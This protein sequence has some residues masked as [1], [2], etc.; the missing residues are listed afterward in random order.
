MSWSSSSPGKAHVD[1]SRVVDGRGER[2]TAWKNRV[3]VHPN[4]GPVPRACHVMEIPV[5]HIDPRVYGRKIP[6]P[7]PAGADAKRYLSG[8]AVAFK[9][10]AGRV[11]YAMR[12]VDHQICG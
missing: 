2:G 3:Y 1:R 10:P 9:E 6:G 4:Q 8:D 7:R 11:R 12:F 5:E